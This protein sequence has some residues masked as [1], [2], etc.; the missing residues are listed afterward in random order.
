MV[1]FGDDLLLWEGYE[2]AVAELDV[3][4]LEVWA[5]DFGCQGHHSPA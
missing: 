2:A 3:V 4:G 5:V 1:A